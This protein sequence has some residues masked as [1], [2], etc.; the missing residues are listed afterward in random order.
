M[1]E[2]TRVY[3]SMW[4]YIALLFLII[5]VFLI[6]VHDVSGVG[7]WDFVAVHMDSGERIYGELNDIGLTDINVD[8]F[9]AVYYPNILYPSFS[10]WKLVRLNKIVAI[11]RWNIER[12]EKIKR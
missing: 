6:R 5:V 12:I 9:S 1:E 3:E 4:V 7:R 2:K 10:E 11:P 8:R